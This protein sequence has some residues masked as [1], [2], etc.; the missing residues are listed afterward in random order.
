VC[1]ILLFENEHQ[2]GKKQEEMDRALQYIGSGA[3]EGQRAY[4]QRQEEQRHIHRI[5]S[6]D[7]GSRGHESDAQHGGNRQADAREY[8]SQEQIHG[9]LELISQRRAC[10]SQ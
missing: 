5:Q 2:I 8:R 3:G 4:A 1:G 7:D 9:P 10:G 6:E